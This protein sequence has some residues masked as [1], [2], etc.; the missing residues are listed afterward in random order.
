MSSVV[1]ASLKTASPEVF[2][3]AVLVLPVLVLGCSC[4][5]IEGLQNFPSIVGEEIVGISGIEIVGISGIE[6]A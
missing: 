2:V 4:L 3:S 1:V 5:G 6:I